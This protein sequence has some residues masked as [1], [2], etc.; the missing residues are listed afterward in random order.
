[1]TNQYKIITKS[2]VVILWTTM[3][4]SC[5]K[6]IDEVHRLYQENE[7]I[8]MSET[9]N[10]D[11]TYTLNGKRA[12]R[13]TAPLMIDYGN[14]KDF[15]YQ[16]FPQSVRIELFNKN[17]LEKTIVTADKAYIYKDPDLSELIG[18]VHIK[19]ADGSSLQT[20]RLF[21]DT[22]NKH[23]FGEEET[24]LKQNGE[25]M[26]GVGFD[27]SLDFKNARLNKISGR[28]KIKQENNN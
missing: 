28:M 3:L 19:G 24:I 23:I 4:F 7:D 17:T 16:Y 15:K 13:L 1:M 20:S 26:R 14:H 22:A 8:P 12:L 10:F 9:K 5:S 18:N 21:W 25:E 6:D 27:S 11:L 2:I